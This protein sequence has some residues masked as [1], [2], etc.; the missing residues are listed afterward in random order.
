[1][2]AGGGG[3]WGGRGAAWAAATSGVG[4]ARGAGGTAAWA[5]RLFG[6]DRRKRKIEERGSP[7][8]VISNNSRRPGGAA[9]GSYLILVGYVD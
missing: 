4:R 3:A 7:T 8:S 5:A 1:M 2:R 6:R 9:D